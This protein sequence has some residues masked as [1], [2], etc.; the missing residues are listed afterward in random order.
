M[1]RLDWKYKRNYKCNFIPN[2][3]DKRAFIYSRGVLIFKDELT[4]AFIEHLENIEK[5]CEEIYAKEKKVKRKG[6]SL[7]E[8]TSK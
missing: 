2:K 6:T 3:K 7:Q 1:A 5:Y 4:P 8:T